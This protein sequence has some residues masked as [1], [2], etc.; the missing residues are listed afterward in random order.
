MIS[1]L[2][3]NKSDFPPPMPEDVHGSLPHASLPEVMRMS[4]VFL[5]VR[6]VYPDEANS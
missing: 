2:Q 6:V 3:I 1:K 5:G 4:I